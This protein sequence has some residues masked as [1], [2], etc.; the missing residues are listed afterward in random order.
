MDFAVQFHGHCDCDDPCSC[1][2][3][4]CHY[5]LTYDIILATVNRHWLF[6]VFRF[7]NFPPIQNF[8]L[9]NP[10]P[11]SFPSQWVYFKISIW[12]PAPVLIPIALSRRRLL[13]PPSPLLLLRYAPVA[14]SFTGLSLRSRCANSPPSFT[15][16]VFATPNSH[17]HTPAPTFMLPPSPKKPR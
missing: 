10:P 12:V 16:S 5:K 17:V 7:W 9:F 15:N 6:A 2:L 11:S 8:Q 3:H 14:T 1:P 13:R 4:P